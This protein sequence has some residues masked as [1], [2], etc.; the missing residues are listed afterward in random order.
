MASVFINMWENYFALVTYVITLVSFTG[1]IDELCRLLECVPFHALQWL[2]W[3]LYLLE[4]RATLDSNGTAVVS[5]ML[6][7]I[8]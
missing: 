5:C 6:V 4:Y 2:N 8:L 7:F 3:E 1:C